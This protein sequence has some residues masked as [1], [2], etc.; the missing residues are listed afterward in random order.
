MRSNVLVGLQLLAVTALAWPASARGWLWPALGL[1]AAGTTW[2][3]WAG[4]TNPPGNFNIRPEPKAG[5]Q[6]VTTGPYRLVRHPMYFGVLLGGA[7]LVVLWPVWWK[8]AAWGGLLAVALV[9]AR[10]EER[11]LAA[12]FPEYDAYRRGR[13]FLVPWVW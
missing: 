5:G 13:R 1:G 2:L 3:I 7:G 6:L 11:A 4:R 12:L 8:A 10:L 9:K